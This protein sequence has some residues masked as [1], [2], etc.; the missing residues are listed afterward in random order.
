MAKHEELIRLGRERLEA[1]RD[2]TERMSL[3]TRREREVLAALSGGKSARE[4][5]KES[6][7]SLGTV[8]NHI[9]AILAKFGVST[10][11]AAIARA[12]NSLGGV[13]LVR[14]NDDIQITTTPRQECT[15]A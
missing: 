10:Q 3:L 2:L 7:V 8:R 13:C 12:R 6:F 4:I 9:H 14:E 5:A 1:E 11:V 15:P